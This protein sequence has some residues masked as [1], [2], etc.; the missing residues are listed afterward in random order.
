MDSVCGNVRTKGLWIAERI[1]LFVPEEDDE[2]L[3]KELM[4]FFETHA[5]AV[6]Y[7]EWK[8]QTD[9]S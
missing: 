2:F 4:F 1:N 8:N 3:E 6:K 5:E 9:K 7:A